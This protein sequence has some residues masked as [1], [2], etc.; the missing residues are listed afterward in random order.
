MLSKLRLQMRGVFFICEGNRS[1]QPARERASFAIAPS[2]HATTIHLSHHVGKWMRSFRPGAENT[3]PN[4]PGFDSS[5]CRGVEQTDPSAGHLAPP[6]GSAALRHPHIHPSS[7]LQTDPK[8][9]KP[10]LAVPCILWC[11]KPQ[12]GRVHE[13]PPR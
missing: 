4:S 2:L 6:G 8:H 11:R 13:G 3:A 10:G 1:L 5:F 7:A 12:L 9:N